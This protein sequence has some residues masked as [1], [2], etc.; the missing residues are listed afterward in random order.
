MIKV[1][2]SALLVALSFTTYAQHRLSL[3]VV[4]DRNQKLP[5]A[6]VSVS[7]VKRLVQQTNAEGQ[8]QFNDLGSGSYQ[9]HVSYVGYG[10]QDTTLRLTSNQFVRIQL[11]EASLRAE[12]VLVSATRARSNASTSFSNI[13]KQ[14]IE[15]VN[16]GRDIP[17][18]LDQTPSVVIGSDAGNGIG[19][20]NMTIRGSSNERINVTLDGIP[21]NDAESMGSFFVNIPDFASSV[22]NIQVQRGIGTSTNGAGAFGASLNIQ[23]DALQ[24]KPYAELNN[25]YGSYNSW[26]NTV[27]AGTGLI[28]NRYAF[29]ARLSRVASDGYIDRASSDLK[30]F[31]VDGGFYGKKQS[32]K[33]TL[34]SGKEKTYQA[35]YGTPEPLIKGD[36]GR[37][38]DYAVGMELSSS[39]T[40]RLLN[41]DRKYNYYTYDNQTDN[42]TQTHARIHYNNQV[43]DQFNFSGAL[44]YTRGAG[45]YEEYRADDKL[46]KYGMAPVIFGTDTTKT[47]DLIRRRWLDNHFYGATYAFNYTPSN[48]LKLTLGGAFNQYTGD[49]YGE[50]IW[51]R[52]ASNSELGDRYYENNAK[53]NDFNIYGKVNYTLDK[54][55]FNVDLQYRTLHYKIDG[56]D[57][58]I[59][60]INIHDDLSFFNP[61]AGLTYLI[62]AQ[63][64]AYL[65]YAYASK[66]PVRKDY[67][68]NPLN[69]FPTPER[70]QNIEAGYRL[71][72]TSFN[73]GAN[74][75]AMLY[76]DQLIPTGAIN[77]VGGTIRQNVP[78][79]YR[80]GIELDAAWN[81]TEQFTWRATAAFSQNKIKNFKEYVP[82]YDEDWND[83]GLKEIEYKKTNIALSA[84]TI[85]SN[86]FAYRPI[87]NLEFSLRTKYV[88]R[89]YLD[90]TSS[91]E[92]SIDPFLVNDLNA[93]YSFAA[94]GLKNVDLMVSV[95]NILGEKYETSGY[96][97]G[98]M[99]TT[100]ERTFYNFYTPQATANYMMGINIRF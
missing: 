55:L 9:V 58:K 48:D 60:N 70:M 52:F 14:T 31:Y 26:K 7:K 64:N 8:A 1:S 27:K 66:E 28:N 53:K 83:L 63:S 35:W 96:T 36:R 85:L 94:L 21:L 33:A 62:N 65:S 73:V 61:K 13:D 67:V 4:N 50:V 25:S 79:S 46:S 2:I 100:G 11:R 89:M 34:F 29:N 93:R 51:S 87:Q 77:D 97:W 99:N 90:N 56:N 74:A 68:E 5:N 69:A 49:H 18:L 24:E 98:S 37:L 76:K 6:S 38:A 45:Y 91:R 17:Y 32:L 22:D 41:A 12:E 95:N 3:E 43:S 30:S 88:S 82:V 84:A 23:T 19:Y 86:E 10:T 78:D 39:E 16:M 57:D 71:R 44:H 81:I 20:T 54:W 75:Y 80:V 72:T 42:Y 47:S 40:D 59:K 15:K 92:R